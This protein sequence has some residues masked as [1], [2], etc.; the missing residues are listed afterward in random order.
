MMKTYLY[1]I[2]FLISCTSVS[3]QKTNNLNDGPYIFIENNKL[4]E[5]DIVNGKVV[6][7]DLKQDAYKTS[8][9]PDKAEFEGVDKI[10]VLSDIH[11]QYKLAVKILK[12]NKVID[13]NLNWNFKKGH[14]VIVGDIFDRGDKVNE[15]FLLVYKLEQQAKKEGGAVHFVLGNHEYMVFHKNYKYTNQ[16]YKQVSKLLGLG[17]N[18]LYG[19]N[20]VMGRWLRSKPTILKIN[21]LIFVH[22]GISEDFVSNNK[23][24]IDAI[25]D[26]MR[27]SIDMDESKM[28]SS[29]YDA[30]YGTKGPIWY[31]GYFRDNLKEE[32]VSDIL[33]A[34]D[35][36][37]IIVGHT[38]NTKIVSLYNN[39]IFGVDSSIK[40]GKYGEVL[41]IEKNDF[42][43]GTLDGKKIPFKK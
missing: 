1:S 34:T 17:Y 10:A 40:N 18:Q 37:H 23:F 42:Y 21:N 7:K 14:L 5:K 3:C 24:D 27:K 9:S 43:R 2:I 35:C 32:Q 15:I 22:G 31:R 28:K 11:G 30:Y 26:A 29:F 19:N 20:T 25:N 41:L 33:K 8:F 13:N 39:K 12:A 4:V 38:S 36:E 6:T 16:K